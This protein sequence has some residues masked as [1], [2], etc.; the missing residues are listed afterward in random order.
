MFREKRMLPPPAANDLTST[1]KKILRLSQTKAAIDQAHA[2]EQ[3][4]S[5][6]PDDDRDEVAS[7]TSVAVSDNRYFSFK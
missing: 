5:P 7:N 2:L 3:T 1:P 4:V 6:V